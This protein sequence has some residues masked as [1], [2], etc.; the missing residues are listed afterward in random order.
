MMPSIMLAC[1]VGVSAVG[2]VEQS[3]SPV[4]GMSS[5]PTYRV[6]VLHVDAD[7]G[8]K[9][10]ADGFVALSENTY[11]RDG[12]SVRVLS[13]FV[14]MSQNGT[15]HASVTGMME[16]SCTASGAQ[17]VLVSHPISEEPPV[18][19]PDGQKFHKGVYRQLKLIVA[20][21]AGLS[22]GDVKTAKDLT[23]QCSLD[24][25]TVEFVGKPLAQ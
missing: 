23:V 2:T 10:L 6:T 8:D 19:L 20:P 25:N 12:Q 4:F 16:V 15:I 1:A 5:K 13:R 21:A 17:D 3:A 14:D 22:W 11:Q 24:K 18:L 7:T 9:W